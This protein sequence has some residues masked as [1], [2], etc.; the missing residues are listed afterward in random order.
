MKN[1]DHFLLEQA[2]QKVLNEN[3][4]FVVLR[5]NKEY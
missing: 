3:E 4:Q 1:K 2:Y 5:R